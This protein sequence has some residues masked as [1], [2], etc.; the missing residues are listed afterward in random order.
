MKTKEEVIKAAYGNYSDIALEICDVNGWINIGNYYSYFPQDKEQKKFFN[1]LMAR[2][3]S[4]QGIEDNNGWNSMD[5]PSFEDGEYILFLRFIDG[6]GEPPI[7]TS[8]LS[9]DFQIGYFTHWKRINYE[10][11]PIY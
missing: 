9:D 4:L 7:F 10:K 1:E 11:P 8:T 2:P 5:D 3:K 6:E